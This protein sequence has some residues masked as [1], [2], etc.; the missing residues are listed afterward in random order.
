M[1]V[2]RF[3]GEMKMDERSLQS[4]KEHLQQEDAQ[5]RILQHIQK[6]R[7]EATVTISR[8]AELFEF[9]ENKL[10]DWEKYGFLNPLRPVGPM[11]RRLYTLRDLDKLA[12]IR[13][14]IDAGYSPGDIPPDI[15]QLWFS[16][17]F[18]GSGTEN[19]EYW[20][21]T[22]R[23]SRIDDLPINERIERARASATFRYFASRALRLSL[24]LICEDMPDTQA[25]LLLPLEAEGGVTLRRVEDITRLGETLVGWLDQTRSS[26]TFLTSAPSF[27]YTSDYRLHPLLAMKSGVAQEEVPEDATMIV[28]PRETRPLTLGADTIEMIRLLLR[29][30]YEDVQNV[31]QCFGPGM[32]D[33]PEPATDLS[34]GSKYED[35][36]LNGLAELIVHLGNQ[37]AEGKAR[38]HFCCIFLPDYPSSLLSL[39]QRS[40]VVRAQSKYAPYQIGITTLSSQARATG[41]CLKAFQSGHIIQL[42]EISPVDTTLSLR[43]LEDPIGSAV[44]IPVEDNDGI[45]V[46]VIYVVSEYPQAFSRSD[47]RLLRLVG[48]MVGELLDIYLV[49]LRAVGTLRNLMKYPEYVDTRFR[50]FL[51]ENEFTRDIDALLSEVQTRDDP[52]KEVVSFIAVDIDNQ[53]GLANRYGDQIAMDLVQ[54]VGLRIHGQLRAFKDDAAYELYH[55]NTDR[56]YIVLKG[57]SLDQ[58]RAKAELLRQILGAPY[59]ID[60]L[61]IPAGQPTLHEHMVTFSNISV[62]L[63]VACYFYWKLKEV[64]LRCPPTTAVVETRMQIMGF[65]E[66]VLDLGKREGG[67]VVMSWEPNIRGFV[68][69]SPSN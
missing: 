54:T 63:G 26:Y 67:N 60:P 9:T 33:M 62:R 29:P 31:R 6:G 59:Q 57:L 52:L 40:L 61:R 19:G 21:P 69:T 66:E 13:E 50:D 41:L 3:F 22:L 24:L 42:P 18:P 39:Q 37:N 48:K 56:Y 17:Y 5:K 27:E 8:A 64:L 45:S 65:L 58:A 47:L 2:P 32:R 38:W 43:E 15:D 53:S 51:S 10:R 7:A 14:L 16:A 36:I 49:R 23:Q 25:G 30:L 20:N 11:G 55:I 12:I 28:V 44:A 35:D 1:C 34:I 68:R 4:I 46:G